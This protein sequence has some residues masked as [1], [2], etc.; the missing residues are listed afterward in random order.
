MEARYINAL[1]TRFVRRAS[2]YHFEMLLNWNVLQTL[3]AVAELWLCVRFLF[4]ATTCCCVSTH[5]A[6]DR[7]RSL[8]ESEVQSHSEYIYQR[9]VKQLS[10]GVAFRSLSPS[11]VI[12]HES[13]L[14]H[15]TFSLHSKL[16][17]KVKHF[18]LSTKPGPILSEFRSTNPLDELK[19]IKS[20]CRRRGASLMKYRRVF[21]WLLVH[22]VTQR[23][24]KI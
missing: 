6:S 2:I 9:R 8:Y 5:K 1:L 7:N 4:W 24:R 20:L 16:E 12:Q 3:D 18:H 15:K 17:A 11:S 19:F 23:S 13:D 22:F 21:N 14:G 10:D